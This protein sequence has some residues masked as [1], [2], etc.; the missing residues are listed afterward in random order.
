MDVCVSSLSIQEKRMPRDAHHVDKLS[1]AIDKVSGAKNIPK[2]LKYAIVEMASCINELPHGWL[3]FHLDR[4]AQRTWPPRD[5]LPGSDGPRRVQ[6]LPQL[7]SREA[8]RR[9]SVVPPGTNGSAE[10]REEYRIA[11]REN[12]EATTDEFRI[13]FLVRCPNILCITTVGI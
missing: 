8:S 6:R 9:G 4:P 13:M 2:C 3:S 11:E 5:G 10:E 1:E 12:P 7:R